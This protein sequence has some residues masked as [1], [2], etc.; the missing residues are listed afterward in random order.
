MWEQEIK[1]LYLVCCFSINRYF[2]TDLTKMC[3]NNT[4][5][6]ITK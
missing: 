1:K 4:N 5:S 6:Y 2:C 3:N